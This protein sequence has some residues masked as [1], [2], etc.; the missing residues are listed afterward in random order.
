MLTKIGLFGTPIAMYALNHREA[1]CDASPAMPESKTSGPPKTEEQKQMEELEKIFQENPYAATDPEE[2]ER[3]L[4]SKTKNKYKKPPQFSRLMAPIKML[5]MCEKLDGLRF[6]ISGGPSESFQLG[7]VWN[8]SNTS[9]PNFSLLALYAPKMNR[10]SSEG[11]TFVNCKKD[12]GGKMELASNFHLG[13]GFSFKA[14]GFFPN[15]NVDSA[16]ISYELMKEFSDWHL[17][18]KFG[19]GSYSLG[20]MQSLTQ[21]LVAGFD[22]MWHPQVKDF[23]FCY[24]FKYSKDKHTILGQYFPLAKKDYIS[25]AYINRLSQKLHMFTEFRASPDGFSDSTYGFKLRF[26]SGMVTGTINSDFKLTSSVQMAG[27]AMLNTMLNMT[28]D[29]KKPERNVTVGLAVSFGAGM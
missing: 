12:V 26:S 27:D 25:M 19:G 4:Q 11:M 22:A 21:D 15:E 16:H 6:E 23:V 29:L 3:L 18:A 2:M 7:A 28:M 10:F 8:F 5:T 1:L 13:N 14:E 24:G 9:P 20:M 17:A